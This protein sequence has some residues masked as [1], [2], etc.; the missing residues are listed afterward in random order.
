MV[1]KPKAA[2][3]MALIGGY[4]E[5][6]EQPIAKDSSIPFICLTD[7]PSLTSETWDIRVVEPAFAGDTI[8]SARRLK[9][10]GHPELN[11]TEQTLWIDNTVLLKEKPER[12]LGEWLAEKDIALPLHSY[13][14][15]V[16]AEVEAVVDAGRDDADRVYEQMLTYMR[17]YP[18]IMQSQ[19]YWT[20]MV[21]RRHTEAV[22]EAMTRWW[23]QVARYS[24]RDQISF[25]IA[26]A[27]LDIHRI[28]IDNKISDLHRWPRA[29]NRVQPKSPAISSALRPDASEVGRLQNELDQLTMDSVGAV[30]AR[31]A[32]IVELEA[33]L[34]AERRRLE[35]ELDAER[36][37]SATLRLRADFVAREATQQERENA[38][39]IAKLRAVID[40]IRASTSWRV[41]AP[42]RMVGRLTRRNQ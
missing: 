29:L 33:E 30:N 15:S 37:E 26:T 34:G 17:F 40:E 1:L 23:D 18:E 25:P 21:A 36:R 3:Y 31:E 20:G 6:L 9:I 11:G 28:E 4:E 38:S 35:G 12:I 2:V 22:R 7:D 10:L 16:I 19:P 8:R 14:A 41:S 39:T 27:E 13:R 5:L 24:R 42:V 32:R